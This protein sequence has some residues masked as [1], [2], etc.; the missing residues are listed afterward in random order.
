MKNERDYPLTCVVV[1][2]IL[3][4]VFTVVFGTLLQRV[5]DIEP[6]RKIW[7]ERKIWDGA[8]E[9]HWEVVELEV[10]GEF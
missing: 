3:G 6:T 9:S 7:A 5:L 8:Y 1:V 2:A 10:K 4:M